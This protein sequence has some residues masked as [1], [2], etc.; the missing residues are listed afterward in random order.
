MRKNSLT[1]KKGLS[2]SQATSISNLC[3]QRATEIAA[4]LIA[5]NNL[6]KSVK[7]KSDEKIIVAG[8][9]L[10]ENT[11]DLLLEK[12]KL[13]AC[14][15]FLMVNI[16]AKDAL[17]NSSHLSCSTALRARLGICSRLATCAMT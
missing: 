12:S 14:Q 1:P 13:H 10:P 5:V 16:K 6:S 9:K 15:A 17:L 2:L 3:H 11:L 7:I 4:K 8:H